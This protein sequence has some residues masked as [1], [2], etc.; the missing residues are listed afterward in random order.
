MKN[1]LY[2]CDQQSERIYDVKSMAR[3]SLFAR[4]N[5]LGVSNGSKKEN[6]A[7]TIVFERKI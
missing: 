1:V 7:F 2:R 3:S 5:D 4:Y 6:P